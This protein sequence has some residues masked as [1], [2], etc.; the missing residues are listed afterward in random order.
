MR[1]SWR[2]YVGVR[3]SGASDS[4]TSALDALTFTNIAGFAFLPTV[5]VI[6]ATMIPFFELLS[7]RFRADLYYRVLFA[8][9]AVIV[10]TAIQLE[11]FDDVA[12][13]DEI[14]DLTIVGAAFMVWH[15]LRACY[16][17]KAHPIELAMLVAIH[18]LCG[19]ALY[20]QDP[21][22]G[23]FAVA[24]AAA[25]FIIAVRASRA[26]VIATYF[27]ICALGALSP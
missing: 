14:G 3:S 27:I 2:S 22:L 17:Q 24:G 9:F 25:L 5:Y 19:A 16:H 10:F 18:L 7:D 1:F 11:I 21:L 6:C 26:H 23:T 20:S 15:G 8:T 13:F 12:S 4:L